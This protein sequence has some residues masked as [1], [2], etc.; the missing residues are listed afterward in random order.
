MTI[1]F[2]V[3]PDAA[4]WIREKVRSIN[5]DPNFVDLVPALYLFYGYKRTDER[6]KIL[7]CFS[8]EY[9]D[10]ACDTLETLVAHGFLKDDLLGIYVAPDARAKLNGSQL[11]L[12]TVEDG[13]PNPS[14]R[15]AHLLRIA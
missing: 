9:F 13:F 1:T 15:T 3:S 8:G 7:A 5:E 12:Q 2:T 6:D 10:V 14:E 4:Q 11:V